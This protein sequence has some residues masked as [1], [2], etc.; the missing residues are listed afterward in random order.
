M[1]VSQALRLLCGIALFLFGMT[2]MGDGLKKS[3]GSKLEPILFRLSGTPLRAILL[4]TGV[5][6]VLQS[7]CATSVMAVGFV[8][9]G[10]MKLRQSVGVILGSI[11]GTSITGWIICLSYIEGGSELGGLL[12][13]KTLTAI[14]AVAG[15]ILR[16]FSKK[17]SHHPVGDILMGFAILM[18]GMSTMSGAVESLGSTPW[19]SNM[20]ASMTHPLL[21]ILVGAMFTAILQSAS[22]AVGVLQALSVTGVMTWGASYPLLLGVTVGAGAP[23]LLSAL[24]ANTEGKRAALIYPIASVLGVVI[25]GA[26][27]Y[28]VMSFISS[29]LAEYIMDPF[30]LAGANTILRLVMLLLLAPAMKAMESIVCA[31]VPAKSGESDD[32]AY[33]LEERFIP[34]PALALEQSTAVI[35]AMADKAEEAIRTAIGLLSKFDDAVFEKVLQLEEVGD[36]YEDALSSYLMKLTGQE[37]S[38]DHN[39]TIS[40]FLHTLT[41]L[42]RISDHARNIAE[43]AEELYVKSVSL[44]ADVRDELNIVT[45]AVTD[46]IRQ[47]VQAFMHTDTEAAE[48]ALVYEEKIDALSYQL[49]SH[50]IERLQRGEC[51]ILSG[52]VINDL[53]TDLER[54]SDHCANIAE[55]VIERYGKSPAHQPQNDSENSSILPDPCDV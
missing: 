32:P 54:V 53:A 7:S 17:P 20:L 30:S 21:G 34:Y 16:L 44:P 43:S 42:E 47:T 40:M 14:I 19:F 10:M 31:I 55:A 8:N 45:G 29:S 5:T 41:D 52:F 38:D 2:L 1:N 9:S 22:A 51:D 27:Y 4:G 48:N 3:S 33:H 35:Y 49:Q 36:R 13:V 25:C 11:L 50:H 15:I 23:V 37:L 24:G 28:L 26:V 6:A 12:S 46:A 39:R 18:L